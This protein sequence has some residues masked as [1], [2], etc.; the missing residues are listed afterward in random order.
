MIYTIGTEKAKGIKA[1]RLVT[2]QAIVEALDIQTILD[3]RKETG[4]PLSPDAL[5][6]CYDVRYRYVGDRCNADSIKLGAMQRLAAMTENVLLLFEEPSPGNCK[7]HEG[8]AMEMW[9]R[10]ELPVTHIFCDDLILATELQR[11]IREDNDYATTS[12][13]PPVPSDLEDLPE[14][15]EMPAVTKPTSAVDNAI[16]ITVQRGVLGNTRKLSS[17]VIETDADKAMLRVSKALID[18]PELEAVNSLDGRV[19]KFLNGHCVPSM[20]PHTKSVWFVGMPLVKRVQRRLLEFA[21]ERKE[22]VKAVVAA[23]PQRV[24]EAAGSGDVQGKLKE[25]ANPKDYVAPEAVEAEFY[26]AWQYVDFGVS[27]KLQQ[28]DSALFEQESR[29]NEQQWAEATAVAQQA[30][31]A[32]MGKLVDHM[33]ERLSPSEDGKPKKF[34]DTLVTNMNEFLNVFDGRNITNDQE[35]KAMVERARQLVRGVDPELLRSSDS[36][37]AYVARGFEQIKARVDTMIVNA[38]RRAFNFDDEHAA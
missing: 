17:S 34:N 31:R 10:F 37:R 26:F 16:C 38:P 24:L 28:I 30:L 36:A 18:S 25:F 19:S 35:L 6:D 7:R 21:A 8:L 14:A 32:C 2:L 1:L 15:T 4:E 20:L 13:R 29:R 23:Y 27:N 33:V 11:S 5:R 3:W 9:N 22:L 12:W